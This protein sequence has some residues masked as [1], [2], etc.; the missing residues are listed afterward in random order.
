MAA[1][2]FT[3]SDRITIGKAALLAERMTQRHFDLPEDEWLKSPYRVFTHRDVNSSLYEPDA[4]AAIVRYRSKSSRAGKAEGDER[5][6][7][8]LQDPNMLSALLRSPLHD[9]WTLGLF[10]LTHELVHITR[11]RKCNVD[12]FAGVQERDREEQLVQG[13]T[14]EI[15][16]GVSA[17]DYILGLY[18]SE[19][20]ALCDQ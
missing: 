12:F 3:S 10:V 5:Y 1:G 11:F 8:V 19:T 9:L 18:E 2:L 6:G 15:L 4:F 7:I 16:A 13:I 20:R 17:I 14:R